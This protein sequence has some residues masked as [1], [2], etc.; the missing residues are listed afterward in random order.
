MRT[1]WGQIKQRLAEALVQEFGTPTGGLRKTKGGGRQFKIGKVEDENRELSTGEAE[2][3]FPGSTDAWAEVVPDM[4]PEFPFS[5]PRSIKNATAWFKIGPTLRTAFKEAPQIEL[6]T[7]DPARDDWFPLDMAAEG[8]DRHARAGSR[9]EE[10][11]NAELAD[12]PALKK[13]SVLVPDDVKQPIA[14]WMK[15]MGLASAKKR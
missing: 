4:F 9:P 10:A 3:L 6:A 7:W 1:T 8:V 14:V 2:V 5:D 11:Y 13:K 12:D 15:K